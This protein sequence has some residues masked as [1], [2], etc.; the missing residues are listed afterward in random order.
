MTI[1]YIVTRFNTSLEVWKHEDV[2][3]EVAEEDKFQYFLR[4][5]E[6]LA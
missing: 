1:C 6:T 2:V 3:D 5:M 4:G